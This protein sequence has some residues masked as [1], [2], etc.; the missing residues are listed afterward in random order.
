MG[1]QGV[2]RAWLVA[3]GSL[4]KQLRRVCVGTL[5]VDVLAE[6]WM[7]VECVEA[8]ALGVRCGV[9][10]WRREVVLRC[11]GQSYVH[12]VSFTERAGALR[13]GLRRLGRRPLGEV[14]FARGARCAGRGVVRPFVQRAPDVPWRRWSVFIVHGY[15][16]LLYEDFMAALP[17]LRA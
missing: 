5:R 7:R 8:R 2:P 12:A 15:R 14:L 1:K 17:P 4:T 16:V 13:L 11:E 10:V 3:P 6:G 9:W